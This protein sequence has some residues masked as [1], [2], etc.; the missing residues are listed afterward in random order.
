MTET[1]SIH[2][3]PSTF[4]EAPIPLRWTTRSCLEGTHMLSH[5]LLIC[6]ATLA[7]TTT[8]L[9]GPATHAS[10]EPAASS[11]ASTCHMSASGATSTRSVIS[12]LHPQVSG[13]SS[14]TA[15]ARRTTS[16]SSESGATALA[17]LIMIGVFFVILLPACII[18]AIV[19][20]RARKNIHDMPNYTS[21]NGPQYGVTGYPQGT[22]A[23]GRSWYTG[24]SPPW[25]YKHPYTGRQG[26]PGSFPANG[27]GTA[28]DQGTPY[29]YGTQPPAEPRKDRTTRV[30]DANMSVP[31]T[32]R[33]GAHSRT[34][35][36]Y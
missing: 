18:Q 34:C 29:G 33:C 13:T 6:G 22:E 9:I 32:D 5:R 26:T 35:A 36:Y 3:S 31:R 21:A 7:C 1:T 19:Y 16:T 20:R 12:S 17:V 11:I 27:Y 25:S 30:T 23:P 15:P 14:T 28:P 24:F 2:P 10:A 8:T 4:G